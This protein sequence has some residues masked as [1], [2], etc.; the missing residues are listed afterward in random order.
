VPPAGRQQV[1]QQ[2]VEDVAALREAGILIVLPADED[3]ADLDT[4]I[5]APVVSLWGAEFPASYRVGMSDASYGEGERVLGP[6]Q[7][8][9]WAGMA[10]AGMEEVLLS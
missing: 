4:L 10:T 8:G 9:T 3:V 6:P 7:A 5:Q 1:V 2:F